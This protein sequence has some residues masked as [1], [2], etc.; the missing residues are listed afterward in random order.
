MTRL[1][2][3]LWEAI[4]GTEQDFTE[5]SLGRA[6]LL[7]S[8]PMVLEMMMEAVFAVADIFFVSKLGA[9][10]VATVG[11]T[12]SML[13]LVYAIGMGLSMATTA[14]VARRIG[15]KNREGAD[16][17]AGQ[18]ILLGLAV[19]VLLAVPG[20]F[21]SKELLRL[22]G[23]SEA[24]ILEGY[25]YPAIMI[26]SNV[27][28]MLLF[29]INAIFRSSGDAAISMRVLWLANLC[30]IVLDPCLIF[31]LGPFPEMGIAGAAVATVIG[32]G[33][34][35]LYQ[36]YLLFFGKCR[37][38]LRP[39]H[40]RVEWKLLNRLLRISYGG[41]AQNI[42]ATSSWIGLMRI[43]AEFG[44]EVLAG[45]TI[46]I[47][48]VIFSLLP[49]WGLSNA[50]STLV[51]QNLGAGKPDRAEKSVWRTSFI[52]MA[53]LGAFGILFVLQPDPFIRFFI[54]DPAVIQAG[55]VALRFISFGYLAYGFGMV[56][57]QAFN[58][59]GDTLTPTLMNLFCFW[60]ME[61]PLAWLFAL[62]FG[63]GETGVYWA[64]VSAETTLA[65]LGIVLFRTGKWK[66]REL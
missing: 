26:S 23:V 15:Q 14:M 27:V 60:A 12:E 52:N 40:F 32:R 30:N 55:S 18:A 2:R 64:I 21:W 16:R 1:L 6:I 47:R 53:V 4:S 20:L 34:A 48:V 22:M 50:A 46:A 59:A 44:S 25:R 66:K 51:G 17:A 45:Y 36:F 3:D 19:S 43:M 61:I 65:L 62:S 5:G 28:I 35:V 37:I 49:S 57:P 31:G 54:A 56:M 9:G 33:L 8:V 38:R 24:L 7:L 39:G 11:I 13:T 10:A 58:G 41:I 42:I 29:I 63:W